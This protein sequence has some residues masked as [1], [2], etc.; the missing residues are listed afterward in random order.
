M[1]PP[2]MLAL[3]TSEMAVPTVP[4]AMGLRATMMGAA[5]GAEIS[6][7]PSQ[8][9]GL[10]LSSPTTSSLV[11]SWATP[12]N[13][14]AAI[15]D[16]LVE[17]SSNGGTSYAAFVHAASTALTQ[18]LTGLAAGT[19]YLVRISA[20]NS[21]GTGAASAAVSA[22]TLAAQTITANSATPS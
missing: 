22:S 18:T 20:I 19:S 2:T 1:V 10:A 11:A 15:T 8:V 6:S 16:Y 14:G 21:V 13:G 12:A 17:Y 7:V 4:G 3:A 5:T 9:G